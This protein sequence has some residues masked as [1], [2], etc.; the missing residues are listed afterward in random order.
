M[1]LSARKESRKL[2]DMGEIQGVEIWRASLEEAGIAFELAEEYFEA[3]GVL[4]Q[5]DRRKFLAEYFGGG[6]GFWL[7]S[8]GG[9]LAGCVGLRTMSDAQSAE[10]KRMYVQQ[11]CRGRGIAQRLL[12]A[13]EEFARKCGYQWIYLDTTDQMRAAARLYERN[14]YERCERYNENPQATIFMKKRLRGA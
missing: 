13:A 4:A 3:A 1:E 2:P 8:V 14:G 11:E 7:A 10:I 9:K 6:R 5:D 12:D